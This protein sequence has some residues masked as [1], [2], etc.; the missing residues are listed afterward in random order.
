MIN[1]VLSRENGSKKFS[2]LCTPNIIYSVCARFNKFLR[3]EKSLAKIKDK[4]KS[5][6]TTFLILVSICV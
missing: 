2:H 1:I 4:I 6:L 3:L 5:Y